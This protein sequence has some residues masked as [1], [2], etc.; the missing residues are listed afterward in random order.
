MNKT[1]FGIRGNR[2][3]NQA[4]RAGTPILAAS[5]ALAL[6]QWAP[7]AHADS[8]VGQ[9]TQIGNA[10]NMQPIDPYT[11]AMPGDPDGRGPSYMDDEAG[12]TAAHTPTGQMY[13]L[14]PQFR[15]D[16]AKLSNG[17]ELTGHAEFGLTGLTGDYNRWGFK[18]YKDLGNGL[19]V[20]NF[21]LAGEHKDSASYFEVTGG[22]VGRDDQF[23]NLQAGRYNDWKVKAFY[24]ETVHVFTTNYRSLF[25]G[26]GTGNLTL[27]PTAR[28]NGL[29]QGGVNAD[30]SPQSVG[31]YMNDV[32]AT[33]A[34]T[35]AGQLGLTRQ[36]GG[37]RADF[38]ALDNWKFFAS[39]TSE[40][41][42]GARPFGYTYGTGGTSATIDVAEPIDYNTYD[43]ILGAQYADKLQSFNLT[44]T[45]SWFRNNINTLTIENPMGV[46]AFAIPAGVTGLTNNSYQQARMDLYPDNDYY[47]LKGEY[48][49][50]LPDLWNGR[51]TVVTALATSQQNDNLIPFSANS[52][53]Y[54]GLSNWDT[55]DSLSKTS[56]GARI[57][58]RLV[59]LGLSLHPIDDLSLS[60]KLRYYQ[61]INQTNFLLC[62]RGTPTNPTDPNYLSSVGTAYGCTGVWGR[63]GDDG[64]TAATGGTATGN[65]YI[66]NI[67]FDYAQLN[68]GFDADYRLSSK[69]SL[70]GSYERETYHRDDRERA[71]TWEDKFKLGYVNRGIEDGTLR[72]S[73]EHDRRRGSQY[74]TDPYG[75]FY[76]DYIWP[77]EGY[78]AAN[79]TG[80]IASWV[81]HMNSLLRKY[82]LADRDQDILNARFNYMISKDLDF[83][84]SGQL[85]NIDYPTSSYG[86]DK[87][88]LN[89]LNFDLTWQPTSRT[90]LSGFYSWQKGKFKQNGDPDNG[91]AA[92]CVIG[93]NGVTSLADAETMCADPTYNI[94]YNSANSWAQT[95]H[96][97]N[98]TF[99]LGLR[100]QISDMIL[101]VNYAFALGRTKIDYVN[102]AAYASAA[103][104]ALAGNGWDTLKTQQ[105]T[106]ELSLT[107]PISKKVLLRFLYRYEQGTINDWH[108]YGLSNSA[109]VPVGTSAATVE[110]GGPLNYHAN[111]FGV[112][113]NVRL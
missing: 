109:A 92:T 52:V 58:T 34:Q 100:Q 82:D 7:P 9:D 61:T 33:F 50:E 81:V 88:N 77:V 29:R 113:L 57:N 86:R 93:N 76:S 13:K 45:G 59:N 51:F 27:S 103:Q 21:S 35:P 2:A 102:N 19:Y 65:N 23:Y 43:A 12:Q 70:N 83:G 60:G 38:M 18:Q 46:W 112:L 22:A 5:V 90:S 105:Q 47:N 6:A 101:D 87:Q 110:D 54:A 73:A 16:P 84:F 24:N 94:M 96:D 3:A 97:S 25:S 53:S 68:T 15:D 37:V 107:K 30:G 1:R 67:P 79:P 17:W 106:L 69:S 14:A 80:N 40:K 71:K 108:Y 10:L 64:A 49:R 55:T 26:V 91:G 11:Y 66:R 44:F 28:A 48:A 20:N 72:L 8:G 36:K 56:A 111:F 85:K 74:N 31:D 98:N 75:A 4:L 99:G 62:N 89:S 39:F 63:L 95:S 104:A 32:N 78:L 41:R 42:Q